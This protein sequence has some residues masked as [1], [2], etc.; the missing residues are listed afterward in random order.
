MARRRSKA[1]ELPDAVRDAVE[2]TVQATVGSAQMTRDRAQEAVDDVVR[3][4]E[5]RAG[6]VRRRVPS[7][8]A[9]RG[10]VFGAIEERRPATQE[11]LKEIRAELRAIA[12]RLSSIEERLPARPGGSRSGSSRASG[13]ARKS[14]GSSRKGAGS[15]RKGGS[16][17]SRGRRAT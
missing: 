5:E 15:A 4:A 16:G 9:V 10:R 7:P 12:R 17:G 1:S 13:S 14:S 6:E 2:R 3:G 11:D 8:E